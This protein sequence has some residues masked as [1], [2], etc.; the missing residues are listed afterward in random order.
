MLG[1]PAYMAPE[2]LVEERVAYSSA[3]DVH[4]LAVLLWTMWAGAA[5]PYEDNV[6]G[7]L[8]TMMKAIEQGTRPSREPPVEARTPGEDREAWLAETP[9]VRFPGKLWEL[10]ESMWA[11]EAE[12]RP[13]ISDVADRLAEE[14]V[15]EDILAPFSSF[16]ASSGSDTDDDPTCDLPPNV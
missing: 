1:S 3:V 12:E 8:F 9:R 2:V 13:S 16:P 6:P 4:S 7:S 15:V 10:L 14:G 5:L 11:A